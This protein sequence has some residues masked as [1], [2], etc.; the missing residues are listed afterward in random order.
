MPWWSRF[1]LTAFRFSFVVR[2][3]WSGDCPCGTHLS[4]FSFL[5]HCPGLRRWLNP[6]PIGFAGGRNLYGFVRND[7]INNWDELGL[8]AFGITTGPLARS[9]ESAASSVKINWGAV[10]ARYMRFQNHIASGLVQSDYPDL[11][12]PFAFSVYDMM[13]DPVVPLMMYNGLKNTGASPGAL[14]SGGDVGGMLMAY[15]AGS[16]EIMG[17]L[18][19]GGAAGTPLRTGF[20]K[21]CAVTTAKDAGESSIAPKLTTQSAVANG[22]DVCKNAAETLPSLRQQYVDEVT[23]LADLGLASRAA[24]ADAQATARLLSAERDALKLKYRALSPPEKVAEWEA[25]AMERWGN[26]LGPTPDQLRAAGKSWDD[27]IESAARPG[28]AD[29]GF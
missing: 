23:E 15:G 21:L 17:D 12:S 19:F 7:P 22:S 10:N 2:S 4:I 3:P 5:H 14:S 18:Y 24:G 29:V 6:D 28:G 8:D 20:G 13:I 1:P 11:K 26:P 9:I 16:L 25:R 27:I